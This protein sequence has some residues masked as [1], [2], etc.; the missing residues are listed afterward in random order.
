MSFKLPESVQI[1]SQTILIRVA[2]LK[3]AFAEYN[4]ETYTVTVDPD[5]DP[6]RVEMYMFHELVHA[7]LHV[8]GV[9]QV[10]ELRVEEA[11][12]WALQHQL[13]PLYNRKKS[14]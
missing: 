10:L 11:I 3:D 4:T 5:T 12:C 9:D 2:K 13:F 6:S 8:S 7:S 14:K 1:G